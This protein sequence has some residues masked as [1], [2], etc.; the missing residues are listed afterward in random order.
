MKERE[1]VVLLQ[2]TFDGSLYVRILTAPN[3]LEACE[4]STYTNG[5]YK[6]LGAATINGVVP[7]PV[8]GY[9]APVHGKIDG[10]VIYESS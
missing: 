4:R 6:V 5:S 10:R 9:V 1:Y 8:N 7:M 3:Q 2:S